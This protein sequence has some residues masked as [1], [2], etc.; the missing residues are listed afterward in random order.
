M[1]RLKPAAPLAGLTLALTLAACGQ[2]PDTPGAAITAGA[3]SAQAVRSGPTLST[4]APGKFQELNQKLKVNIV[5]VGYEQGAGPRNVD[6]K[7]LRAELPGTYR[8]VNRSPKFYGL[9]A[10]L[11]VNFTYD[12][13]V[14][15]ADQNYEDA[16]FGYLKSAAKDAPLT[17][18]QKAYNAQT[19]RT[20]TITSN[21]L[22]DAPSTEKW[23]ANHAPAGVDTTQYTVYLV[24]WYGR[25]DFRDHVYSKLDEPDPDTGTNFGLRD[26]RKLIAWGGTAADDEES[27]QGQ[28]PNARVWFYDLSA[29]PE[30]WTLNYDLTKQDVDGDGEPDERMPPVWEYGNTGA[31]YRPFDNLSRD[32]GRVTRYV[33]LD[34]LFTTSPLYKPA[35]SAPALPRNVQLDINVYQGEAGFDATTLIKQKLLL[36]ELGE[37]QPNTNFSAE[38][39]S[40][41]FEGRAADVYLCYLSG[42]SCYGGSISK[43]G[44]GDLFKVHQTQLMR[45]LEG[46]ADY[47][48]P[49]FA[50]HTGDLD[51]PFLGL[52]DD[53]YA[54]GTQSFVFGAD[55]RATRASYG[56]TTTLIHEVGHHLGMS[57]PHDGYDSETDNDFGAYGAY[58]YANVGDESNSMM[59][60]IDLNWDFSQFDRDNMNRYLT[61]VYLNEANAVLATLYASG[62]AGRVAVTLAAADANAA[63]AVRTYGTMNYAAAAQKAQTAYSGVMRAAADAGVKIEPQAWPA[64]YKAKG[65]SSKFVDTVTYQRSLP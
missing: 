9:P 62:K 19:V 49:I 48:V 25:Q 14:V 51:I 23:L 24:N 39:T 16:F 27:G 43:T 13:N 22:I 26:S 28:K 4:L 20:R 57:H 52:A 31:T 1:T 38:V 3:L 42:H 5:L 32:L 50:Y 36:Q 56:L 11:G 21:A 33:A 29:G 60:Y 12:Y 34:L 55:N 46:D 8:T 53:N 7:K 30:A 15:Y 47:E 2:T 59:S 58:T 10:E 17:A 45:F 40:L 37:L 61:S 63:D 18:Q 35:I 6:A 64:D 65:G 54:D 41:P 44:Y